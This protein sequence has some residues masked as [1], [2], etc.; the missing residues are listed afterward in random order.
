MAGEAL[1][2]R[3]QAHLSPISQACPKRLEPTTRK[4]NA[5]HDSSRSMPAR[6]ASERTMALQGRGLGL[7]RP[8]GLPN[9]LGESKIHRWTVA[10]H[11]RKLEPRDD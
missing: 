9:E 5:N 11:S 4:A 8:L 10:M 7:A 2:M 3:S 6:E 1:S